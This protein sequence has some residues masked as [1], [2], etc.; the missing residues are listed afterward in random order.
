M[1]HERPLLTIAIPTYNRSACLAQLLEILMPQ[2]EG[3][4][5][6]EVIVSDNASQ[7][8]TPH[9]VASFR[10]K[11]LE[12]VYSRNEINGG[13]DVNFIRCYE[14]A[15]GEYV[16]IFGDDDIIVPGGLRAVLSVLESRD[17]DLLHL[18]ASGFQGEYRGPSDQQFSGKVRRFATTE[19]FA[20]YTFTH[21][22]FISA[23][24]SRKATLETLAHE[25]FRKFVGTSLVQLSWI[26]PLLKH[27]VRCACILDRVVANR[28]DN[29]G[30]HGTCE[31]FGANLTAIVRDYFAPDSPSFLTQS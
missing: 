5:R 8:D 23:N 30:D 12:V 14:L 29:G 21:L 2:L 24:I 4:H 31:V 11:G 20:L 7:D 16:W 6:V 1:Q 26:F 9:T 27:E 10:Q 15:R 17:Y 22:T 18:G 3:E 13:A 28:T 25:D 19:E